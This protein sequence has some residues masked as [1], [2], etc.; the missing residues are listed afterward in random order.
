MHLTDFIDISFVASTLAVTLATGL[1]VYLINFYINLYRYPRGPFP[2]P[3]I[4]NVLEFTKKKHVHDIF[5][6]I[7]RAYGG[8][9]TLWFSTIPVIVI[10]DPKMVIHIL[11][12]RKTDFSGRPYYPHERM[13]FKTADIVLGDYGDKQWDVSRRT[14]HLAVRKYAVSD[15]LPYKAIDVVDDFVNDLKAENEKP[16]PM[17]EAIHSLT[18]RILARIAVGVDFQKDDETF[19]NILQMIEVFMNNN[20]F[21]MLTALIPITEYTIFYRTHVIFERLKTYQRDTFYKFL[22]DHEEK[23]KDRKDDDE[24]LNDFTDAIL[25]AKREAIKQGQHDVAE[26]MN[27]NVMC[28]IMYDLFVAGGDTTKDTLLWFLLIISNYPEVQEKI[29]AE[30]EQISTD[31]VPT[32]DLKPKFNYLQA[33]IS[34]TMRFKPIVPMGVPHKTTC[35][36]ELAGYTIKKGT[37]VMA[38]LF[39]VMNDESSFPEP[40]TFKPERFLDSDGLYTPRVANFYPFSVGRRN[41]IGEKLALAN[42]FVITVRMFQQTKGYTF[43]PENGPGSADLTPDISNSGFYVPNPYKIRL[44]KN[45]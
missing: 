19:K 5:N 41:C 1:A 36:T 44:V 33:V 43:V 15:S 39:N 9:T 34:E 40:N 14:G 10:T 35:D 13:S 26:V 31:E 30:V 20:G 23:W 21:I 45:N 16:V 37:L 38:S 42:L 27:K 4:G 7:G 25:A 29:R 17:A 2:L 8:V 3:L 12:D 28:S 22:E 6:A 32:L 24:E 18:F 11:K